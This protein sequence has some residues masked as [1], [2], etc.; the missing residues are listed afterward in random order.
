MKNFPVFS[1]RKNDKEENGKT[2]PVD[3]L[4]SGRSSWVMASKVRPENVLSFVEVKAYRQDVMPA[5][6]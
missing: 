5:D 1:R 2:F 3:E 4:K 6:S